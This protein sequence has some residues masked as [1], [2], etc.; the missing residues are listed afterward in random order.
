MPEADN[1][2]P[3]GGFGRVSETYGI[4]IGG[5]KKKPW[6]TRMS[7]AQRRQNRIQYFLED[8]IVSDEKK[9]CRIRGW[10]AY[11]SPV[12]IRVED[13]SGLRLM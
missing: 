11:S 13:A 3:A 10:A 5:R 8:V 7:Q 12:R 9:C 4:C 1:G 6:F 2:I